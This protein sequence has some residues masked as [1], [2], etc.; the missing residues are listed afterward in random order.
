MNTD[1]TMSTEI[2]VVEDSL[3]QAEYLK[4]ML[5]DAGYRV[6]HATDGLE[7]LSMLKEHRPALVISDIVMPRMDGFTLCQQLKASAGLNRLPVLLLTSINDPA[8]VLR[9]LEVG[10]DCFVFK[11]FDENYL[12]GRVRFLLANPL[13]QEDGRMGVEIQ[14]SGRRF[15]ITSDRLQILNLLLATYEAA[16]QRNGQLERTQD[17]LR[18]L[19]DS[20]ESQVAERTESLRQE[21]TE[22]RRIEQE[23]LLLLDKERQARAEA[24]AARAQFRALFEAAPGLYVVLDANDLTVV[25]ASQAYLVAT[26]TE[27]AAIVGRSIF[28]VLPDDPDDPKAEGVAALRAS[29]RRL[30]ESGQSDPM[31]LQRYPIRTP[32]GVFEERW[33][34]PLNVPVRNAEGQIALILHR[35][36]DVTGYVQQRF[37]GNPPPGVDFQDGNYRIEA[38]LVQRSLELR[39][40]LDLLRRSEA[41]LQMAGRCAQMGGWSM[42]IQDLRIDLSAEAARILGLQAGQQIDPDTALALYHPD[43]RDRVRSAVRDCMTTGTPYDLEVRLTGSGDQLRWVRSIGLAERDGQ[44]RIVRVQGA[45]QDITSQKLAATRIAAH[46]ARLQLLN[47]ITRSI[48]IQSSLRALGQTV[49]SALRRDLPADLCLLLA[50]GPQPDEWR[51][52]GSHG[53]VAG[54][55]LMIGTVPPVD[56]LTPF[57]DG[58]PRHVAQL[59]PRNDF[60]GLIEHCGCQCAIVVPLRVDQQV[61]GLLV[62][63]HHVPD[64]FSSP[65]S[66]F[67]IQL[68][69]HV[70]L[71]ARQAQLQNELTS[72]Y[73]SLQR[74]QRQ[75]VQQERMRASAELASGIAHDINNSLSPLLLHT[76][77][78]SES[79]PALSTR[80]AER[81]KVMEKA[82]QDIT[83]TVTRLRQLQRGVEE[84]VP[85]QA[86]RLN[87]VVQ[88]V[89]GLMEA[90]WQEQ[91]AVEGRDVLV[92]MELEPAL[93]AFMGFEA[94]IRDALTN[95]V[96]N[97]CDAMP[98]KGRLHV[99]TRRQSDGGLDGVCVEIQDNG[100]G[101]D[102]DTVSR[103]LAPFFTTKGERGT[104]LGLA[105]VDGTV[106]RHRGRLDIKSAPDAGTTMTIWLPCGEPPPVSEAA[107]PL[108]LD[109]AEGQP[110]SLLLVDDEPALLSSLAEVLGEAGHTVSTALGGGAALTQLRQAKASNSLPKVL[111][112]DMGM[113]GLDGGEL[114]KAARDL[115]PEMWIVMLS[116]WGNALSKQGT[117]P[118][119]V[120]YLL[121]K[122]PRLQELSAV[123]RRCVE[124]RPASDGNHANEC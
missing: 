41:Q 31:G 104:G 67:L 120:D 3:T 65:D 17:E 2:L 29:F 28:D 119:C 39:S 103:C 34:S 110:L 25:G 37:G 77:L 121:N 5:M 64:A 66:E 78:L 7:A 75:M 9:S 79:E 14:F 22:R 87:S 32:S 122:P 63:A 114:A 90:R 105:M 71:A 92:D 82:L 60:L 26:Y 99:R 48:G 118:D 54:E 83:G 15:F 13:G 94:E 33:W 113:P 49:C 43:H 89:L 96:V 93:P 55:Q 107:A 117:P 8:H 18:Q 27:R 111:I 58:H 91:A 42:E 57:L 85:R 73:M 123:L 51:V 23:R 86:V 45:L 84:D 97:A 88:Q 115:A 35:V 38:E 61:H 108:P 16:V 80:G 81:L 40:T 72:A 46:N 59:R 1:R 69:E 4:V 62:V 19:N 56:L 52:V 98:A 101:M 76:R 30:M 100:C 109:Q 68:G 112:T 36:E 12:I 116:G 95:L 10:A 70:A 124:P 47:E 74:S 106:K 11:P 6:L 102:E 21:L 24:E 53:E 20:L 50:G 44:G